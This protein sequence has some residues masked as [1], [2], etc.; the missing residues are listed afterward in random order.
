[1]STGTTPAATPITVAQI[2]GI[3]RG[4]GPGVKQL[5]AWITAAEQDP[6]VVEF[7]NEMV[8]ALQNN[9]ALFAKMQEVLGFFRLLN[10][11]VSTHVPPKS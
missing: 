8:P 10:T 11:T 1:M 4:L 9:P 3:I 5:I 2:I 7:I 6:T